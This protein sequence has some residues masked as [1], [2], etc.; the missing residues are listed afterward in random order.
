MFSGIRAPG[1]DNWNISAVK[2]FYVKE[3]LKIQFR[4]EFLDALNHTDLNPPNTTPTSAQFG[5][6]TAAENQPRFI[7]FGLK[8][9]F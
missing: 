4:T 9:T 3:R 1:V 7:Y 8:L 2:N 5:Q 6:I